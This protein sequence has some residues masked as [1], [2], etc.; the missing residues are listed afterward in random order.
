MSPT[1]SYL[2]IDFGTSKSS[3]AWYNS[4]TGRAEIIRNKE[5]KE[6]TPSVVYLGQ[7][8]NEVLVGERAERKL[9]EEK[10][11][12]QRFMIS[13]KRNLISAPTRI[14]DGRRYRPVDVAAKILLK[15]K[16]DAENLLFHQTITRAVITYPASFDT[17]Q[18]DK[19]KQ[20]AMIAGFQEVELL[21]EPVS[22]A[23]AYGATGFRVGNYILVY[24]FGGGTF[25]VAVLAR[26]AN[27][28]FTLTLNPKGLKDCGGD[29][30]DRELYDYC[31]EI[32]LQTLRRGIT[33]T[34]DLDLKFFRL[35]RR[36]KEDL[37]SED[38]V[39]VSSYL[40]S[41][42]GPVRFQHT[43]QRAAFEKRASK[44]IE[45]TVL[46]TQE[47]MQEA[48]SNN[49]TVDTIVLIGGSS[50]VPLVSQKL[51]AALTVQPREWHER[52]FA[53]A[54][55]AAYHAHKLWGSRIQ[56]PIQPPPGV[57]PPRPGDQ[58]REKPP[59]SLVPP[60]PSEAYRRALKGM[61]EPTKGINA[62]QRGELKALKR[63]LALNSEEA[64]AIEREIM[65]RFLHDIDK[66]EYRTLVASYRG[67]RILMPAQVQ[68]LAAYVYRLGLSS[69]EASA[70]EREVLGATR[71][72]LAQV[73]APSGQGKGMA[74]AGLVL[75]IMSIFIGI[76]LVPPILGIIF[77]SLGRKSV[78]NR[79]IATV[80]L[81]FSIVSL[82][83]WLL[84]DIASASHP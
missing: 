10:I 43:L 33:L 21:P 76:I 66:D 24:D 13:V 59:Q 30:L 81:W 9:E 4:Q 31:E 8:E 42:N 56:P 25:D 57:Q 69:D 62:V 38:E 72:Q 28:S 84:I 52:D 47:V 36:R 46:L 1:A 83:L 45:H 11:E 82:A 70:I 74:I 60:P 34:G 64:A 2:G 75:G 61:W 5:G 79:T 23:L 26:I 77:S 18:Q 53:V 65:G 51:S 63:S 41:N 78:A 40:A 39:S 12:P 22:A 29:D 67:N 80:G 3:M 27:G 71:E 32:A 55:G 6:E 20:A 15:L 14:V 68:A 7:S 50:R 37:S 54:L 48:R 17:L 16:E 44:Y 35:C 49:Y 73:I 19:I 58:K